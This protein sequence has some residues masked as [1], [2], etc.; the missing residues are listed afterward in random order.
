MENLVERFDAVQDKLL[1]LYEAGHMDLESQILHWDLERQENVLL[2]FARKQGIQNIGMQRVPP[3]AATE[4]KAKTAIYMGLVLRSLKKSSYSQE[5][6]TLTETSN[7]LFM[8]AP[9]NT[10]KKGG[11]T[12]EVLYD[13]EE[14][15][16][17]PY[18][19]WTAIYYQDA[20]DMWHKTQG[21]VD[22]KG[23]FYVD[24][25]GSKTYYEDFAKD[26]KKYGET[27]QWQVK[28]GNDTL[29]GPSIASTSED[30]VDGWQTIATPDTGGPR[31]RRGRPRRRTHSAT[32]S[33]TSETDTSSEDR[34]QRRG[35]HGK[36]RS[37]R[38]RW[39][40]ESSA[41]T[42]SPVGQGHR[43]PNKHY[44]TRLA[45][46]QAEAGDPP[47]LLVKGPANTT[48]CWRYRVKLRHRDLFLCISTA[49]SWVGE[50]GCDRVGC[51]RVLVGFVNETQ[52]E[53]F[54]TTVRLPKGCTYA[55]GNIDSL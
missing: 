43:S 32:T 25:T 45:R 26:A 15:K 48:K 21:Q 24:I 34:R 40:S 9:Q 13:N 18:T 29:F 55:F 38:L 27:G 36:R 7:E 35:R 12:I 4:Q 22:V 1:S 8:T 17:M 10:F 52:R 53:R 14:T 2:H 28:T 19:L 51:A 47:V 11:K 30:N 49:F 33:A 23:L 6:W 54:I 37:K 50:T 39:G 31:R 5:S 16:A 42:P 41:R 44:P 3:L 46:L 20:D